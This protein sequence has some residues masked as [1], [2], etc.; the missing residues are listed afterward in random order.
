MSGTNQN[1][2]YLG[3]VGYDINS[4]SL[5]TLKNGIMLGFPDA[6]YWYV[7]YGGGDASN[8]GRSW[9][10]AFPNVTMAVDASSDG[11]GDT[12]FVRNTN[13]SGS[14]NENIVIPNSKIGIKIIGIGFPDIHGNITIGGNSTVISGIKINGNIAINGSDVELNRCI[15]IGDVTGYAGNGENGRHLINCQIDGSVSLGENTTIKSTVISHPSGIALSIAGDQYSY[16]TNAVIQSSVIIGDVG[17]AIGQYVNSIMLDSLT[18][19]FANTVAYGD[20]EKIYWG[21]DSLYHVEGSITPDGY[22]DLLYE[23]VRTNSSRML[24]GVY[25]D[26]SNMSTGDTTTIRIYVKIKNGGTYKL[27]KSAEYSDSLAEP[28]VFIDLQL[29]FRYGFKVTIETTITSDIEYEV[30]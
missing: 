5:H 1:L 4:D 3:G 16:V 21:V 2:N 29:P 19:V 8:N 20:I 26:L 28:L 7:D 12:I 23:S 11:T 22:E 25:I 18:S 6:N 14:V 27:I 10:S 9:D 30:F 13:L 24:R 17:I 15:I